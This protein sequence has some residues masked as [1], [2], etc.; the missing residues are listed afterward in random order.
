MTRTIFILECFLNN[1]PVCVR[2][3]MKSVK[4]RHQI[5]VRVHSLVNTLAEANLSE[6]LSQQD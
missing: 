5:L 2:I 4:T 3:N 1:L 6:L